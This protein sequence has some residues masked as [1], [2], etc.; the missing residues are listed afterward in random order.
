MSLR[1]Y[2]LRPAHFYADSPWSDHNVIPFFGIRI[3]DTAIF[4]VLGLSSFRDSWIDSW[5]TLGLVVGPGN[6]HSDSFRGCV[7][8]DRDPAPKG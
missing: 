5:E 3:R 2:A 8:L 4:S 1:L 7:S 6:S